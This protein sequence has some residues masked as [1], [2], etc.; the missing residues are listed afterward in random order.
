M[1]RGRGRVVRSPQE[2]A[3]RIALAVGLALAGLVATVHSF[4][5]TVRRGAPERAYALSPGDGRI[6]A[7]LSE[8]LSGPEATA[9]D[10]MRASDIALSALRHD[11]TAVQAVATLGLS[12]AMKGDLVHARDWFRYAQYLSRR[13]LRTQLWA[14]EDAVARGDV[15]ASLHNYDIALRTSSLASDLLFPVLASAVA[16][17]QVRAAVG[18]VLARKPSWNERFID[19]AADH[20]QDPRTIALLFR[21]L[22]RTPVTVPEQAKAIVIQRLIGERRYEDAWA[23]YASFRTSAVQDRSR[24]PNFVADLNSPT[25]FDW[26]PVNDRGIVSSVGNGALNFTVPS[27][28]GGLISRQVQM[29][30]PGRYILEGHSANIDQSSD[31]RPYWS[32][33]CLGDQEVG[34]VV[35]PSSSENGG[36]FKGQFIVPGGCTVQELSLI[37]Q[38]TDKIGGMAAEIKNVVLHRALER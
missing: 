26:V 29:L 16:D 27:S 9:A 28:V 2:W 19:Y 11:P 22:A 20:G 3:V 10:R 33:A 18:K 12:T 4:A 35:L 14:I 36:Y 32:L 5:F 34:R 38:P 6:G 24:D 15:N 25:P 37:A 17:P 7:L 23:Y 8:R 21:D 1:K 13:D 30:P 31:A